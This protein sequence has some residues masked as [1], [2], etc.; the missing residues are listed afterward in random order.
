MPKLRTLW[1][2]SPGEL[3]MGDRMWLQC[4][5]LGYC[6]KA[7][8]EWSLCSSGAEVEQVCWFGHCAACP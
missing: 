7:M 8:P 4:Y 6:E 1:T 5:S 2:Y 3:V